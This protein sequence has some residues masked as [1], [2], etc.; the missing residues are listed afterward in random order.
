MRYIF[1]LFLILLILFSGCKKNEE[2]YNDSKWQGEYTSSA[3]C[4]NTEETTR[5]KTEALTDTESGFG[6][7]YI[8]D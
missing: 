8:I 7:I 5:K 1:S 3:Y 6:E 2:E 4:S